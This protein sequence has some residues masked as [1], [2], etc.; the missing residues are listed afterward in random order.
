MGHSEPASGLCSIAKVLIAMESGVIPSNLHFKKPNPDIPALN[1]GRLQVVNKNWPWN[2][3][4]V[5][6]NSFG[7]GGAN[8]HVLLKSNSKPKTPSLQDPIPRLIAVSGRTQEAVQNFLGKI[9]KLPRDDEFAGLLHKIHKQNIPGHTHRGYILKDA[10]DNC[11]KEVDVSFSLVI[12]H[13]LTN[14][15]DRCIFSNFYRKFLLV[16]DLFGSCFPEW[17][18][19]GP[20]WVNN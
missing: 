9:E 6:V 19:N 17:A 11:T 12:R 8:V 16:K 20:E 13:F 1:D 4:Y 5:A 18:H 15:N 2:G 14:R 10:S 7:F 3:G